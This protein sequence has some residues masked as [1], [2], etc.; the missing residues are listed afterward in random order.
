LNIIRME[1]ALP[2][3]SSA[4]RRVVNVMATIAAFDPKSTSS[5][6]D[7]KSRTLAI[8][9]AD[10]NWFNTEN[11][12]RELDRDGVHTF[13][14]YCSDY[15]NAWRKGERPWSWNKPARGVN[16][17]LWRQNLALPSGWMKKFP[18]L[19]MRPIERA[20]RQWRDRVARGSP[21]ALVMTYPH[22]LYLHD[23]VRP[24]LSVYYN[25]DDY[26]LYWPKYA[27]KIQE[28]EQLTVARADLTLCSS[29]LRAEQLRQTVPGA[30][31]RIRHF[32]HGAP[33]HSVEPA[34]YHR[35]AAPPDDIAHLPRPILGY[36]GSMEDRVDW[37]LLE[38]LARQF[39]S[40]SLVLIGRIPAL[41]VDP[42]QQNMRRLLALPNVHPIG[43]RHQDAL[44][45]YNRAFDVVLIPYLVDHPFNVACCPTKIMDSMGSGRPIL[46]T[47]LPECRLYRHLFDV[48]DSNDEFL[49]RAQRLIAAGSDDGR[50]A[51]RHEH[52]AQNTWAKVA[53]RVLDWLNV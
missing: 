28:L 9:V 36:V 21:L 16:A 49:D 18:R 47:D 7:A 31:D 17:K 11:L 51:L 33:S 44:A 2:L 23:L 38:Q 20:I 41:G 40:A 39:P 30:A 37:Q 34:P 50:A 4:R 1:A 14:L 5:S 43:W 12:F 24:D 15:L 35:P 6:P 32:P 3:A 42:W 22:Y 13:L 8:A 46:S 53:N 26:T 48:A 52:A 29:N 45:S 27:H 25:I 19:G 10:A